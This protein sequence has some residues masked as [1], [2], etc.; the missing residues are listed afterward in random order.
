VSGPAEVCPEGRQAEEASGKGNANQT[1]EKA[2]EGIMACFRYQK[3]C[4]KRMP[5]WAVLWI[6]IDFNA[7]PDPAFFLNADPAPY[8]GQ[9]LKSQKSNF[10]QKNIL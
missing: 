4:K 7:F 6:R 2:S 3:N 10:L 1:L 9:T 5:L 8:P